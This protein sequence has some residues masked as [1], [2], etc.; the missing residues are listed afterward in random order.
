MRTIDGYLDPRDDSPLYWINEETGIRYNTK[1]QP[2]P[3]ELQH[4]IDSI[5]LTTPYKGYDIDTEEYVG[6]QGRKS[7]RAKYITPDGRRVDG[8]SRPLRREERHDDLQLVRPR[9][10]SWDDVSN[11]WA[12]VRSPHYSTRANPDPANPQLRHGRSFTQNLL[13]PDNPTAVLGEATQLTPEE[14]NATA[15]EAK[16]PPPSEQ[17]QPSFTQNLLTQETPPQRT[18]SPTSSSYPNPVAMRLQ[19]GLLQ[20]KK[21]YGDAD[22]LE[23]AINAQVQAALGNAKT[24]DERAEIM[25]A[26]NSWDARITA[27]REAAHSQA[28]L[29][30]GIADSAD[31]REKQEK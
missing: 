4:D 27:T 23:Q 12:E 19:S 3:L 10:G 20:A 16:P 24:D 21:A 14:L 28:E 17:S 11:S 9:P 2:L 8:F 15:P 6:H 7:Y 22:A 29:L 18:A 30:R 25:Q 5:S 31:H 13:T 26:K 1:M